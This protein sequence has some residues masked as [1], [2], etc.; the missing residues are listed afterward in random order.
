MSLLIGV[1]AQKS[2]T[3]WIA[4]YLSQHPQFTISPVKELHYFDSNYSILNRH[5]MRNRYWITKTVKSHL[6]FLASQG[7]KAAGYALDY[8]GMLMGRDQRYTSYLQRLESITGYG[9]EITPAYSIL[10]K[11]GFEG[12]RA[13]CPS[14]R[15]LFIMRNPADRLWSQMRFTNSVERESDV[16]HALTALASDDAVR[17]RSSYSRTIENIKHVFSEDQTLIL[18]YEDLF[19]AEKGAETV[20]NLC[21]FI[22]IKFIE[23]DLDKQVHVSRKVGLD[24]AQRFRLVQGLASEYAYAQGAFGAA[25]PAKW[26]KDIAALG[27]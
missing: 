2:G 26:K 3:T 17:L 22:G 15:I 6:S 21:N 16:D 19:S 13:A 27:L 4:D 10:D 12:I 20:K 1:G 11:D 25:L 8:A 5:A 9:G 24:P 7:Q 14:A 18:F 23:P